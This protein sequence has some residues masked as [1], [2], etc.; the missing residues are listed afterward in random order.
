MFTIQVN[1]LDKTIW[2]LYFL[3]ILLPNVSSNFSSKPKETARLYFNVTSL[4]LKPHLQ[5]N[6]YARNSRTK[7]WADTAL[8]SSPEY[9]IAA[10]YAWIF[11]QVSTHFLITVSH[12]FQ[13]YIIFKWLNI[14][15]PTKSFNLL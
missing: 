4:S 9:Q 5:Y 1:L 7:R 3:A 13:N 6:L 15:Y 11:P 2:F 12:H 14:L 10:F 8:S